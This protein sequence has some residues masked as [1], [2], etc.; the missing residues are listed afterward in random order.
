MFKNCRS[1]V[2]DFTKKARKVVHVLNNR[3][4]FHIINRVL[5]ILNRVFNKV[6]TTALQFRH[7]FGMAFCV[8]LSYCSTAF[9]TDFSDKLLFGARH[10]SPVRNPVGIK[11]TVLL[12]VKATP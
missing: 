5:N 8:T 11:S 1:K 6:K 10:V 12:S 4:V 9:L 7:A 2:T 3:R